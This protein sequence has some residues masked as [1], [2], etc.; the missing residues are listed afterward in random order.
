MSS[1]S[2]NSFKADSKPS[3][4]RQG[5]ELVITWALTLPIMGT[6]LEDFE[7]TF[8]EITAWRWLSGER[9]DQRSQAFLSRISHRLARGGSI[10]TPGQAFR[11]YGRSLLAS[12][13]LE[14]KRGRWCGNLPPARP[15]A[16][17]PS[18]CRSSRRQYFSAAGER[19]LHLVK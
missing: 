16:S 14:V 7:S 13:G 17:E 15:H 12:N 6:S 3:R 18:Q 10:S 8:D 11:T 1:H 5:G 9:R 2:H 4:S 19:A